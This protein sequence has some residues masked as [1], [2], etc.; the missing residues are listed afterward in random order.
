MYHKYTMF[1]MLWPK[2]SKPRKS[3]HIYFKGQLI[4]AKFFLYDVSIY[5]SLNFGC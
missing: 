2:F 3:C 4:R 5:S 1:R